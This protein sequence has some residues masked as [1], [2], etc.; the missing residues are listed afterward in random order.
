MDIG[1]LFTKDNKILSE[2]PVFA[3]TMVPIET[4]VDHLAA[5]VSLDD[6]LAD[7]LSMTMIKRRLS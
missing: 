1:Q 6:L 2:Q 3:G 5:G 4:L 7:F